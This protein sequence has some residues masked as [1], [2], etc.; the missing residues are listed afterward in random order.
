MSHEGVKHAPLLSQHFERIIEQDGC[1]HDTPN[2]I[3][4]LMVLQMTTQ[5]TY[6][7]I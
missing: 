2:K 7:L 6:S 3:A 4:P 5:V 1:N